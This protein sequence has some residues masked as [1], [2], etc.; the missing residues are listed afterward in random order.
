MS[1]GEHLAAQDKRMQAALAEAKA[2]YHHAE[3]GTSFELKV[4]ELL[5][6]FLRAPFRVRKTLLEGPPG[7]RKQL[8]LV[9][10]DGQIPDVIEELPVYAMAVV[11]E[12]KT[13]L[14]NKADIVATTVI[15]GRAASAAVLTEPMPFLVIAGELATSIAHKPRWLLDLLRQVVLA[16]DTDQRLF[17]AV[18]S[19]AE[20]EP[21][22]ALRVSAVSPLRLTSAEGDVLDGF[23]VLH[24]DELSPFVACYMWLMACL[25]AS[26][27]F[28]GMDFRFMRQSVMDL[29]RRDGGVEVTF[30]AHGSQAAPTTLSGCTIHLPDEGPEPGPAQVARRTAWGAAGPTVEELQRA[31][32]PSGTAARA[33]GPTTYM[34][35]RLKDWVDEFDTWDESPWGGD[36]QAARL[37]YGY[38]AGMTEQDLLDACRVFWRI[39][40]YSGTWQGVEHAVVAHAMKIVAVVKIDDFIGPFWGRYGFRGHLET[41]AAL[42]EQLLGRDVPRGYGSP[43]SAIVL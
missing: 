21:L 19:F 42:N 12:V 1:L 14:S 39:N 5:G 20:D 37:G 8:D 41:D 17:P 38:R 15:L 28:Q 36:A 16:T 24:G 31:A 43:V 3:R 27:T 33:G 26:R 7:A 35:V 22:S 13:V 23:V 29:C 4:T 2:M 9:V 6:T 11:G 34:L 40:P 32:R 30:L 10:H 18:F 25:S